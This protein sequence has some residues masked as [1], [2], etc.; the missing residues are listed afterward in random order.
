V[1]EYKLHLLALDDD[2]IVCIE[3]GRATMLTKAAAACAQRLLQSIRPENAQYAV[4]PPTRSVELA[5]KA[6]G[7]AEGHRTYPMSKP[8]AEMLN[9]IAAVSEPVSTTDVMNLCD[10][11]RGTASSKLSMMF[12]NGYL[13]RV[14][15]GRYLVSPTGHAYLLEHSGK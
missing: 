10:L 13:T 4:T 5:A 14:D 2:S 6:N 11:G 8:M 3:Y 7:P 9:N 12:T 1:K 15:K